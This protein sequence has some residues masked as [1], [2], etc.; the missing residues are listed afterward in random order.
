MRGR[1]AQ[2]TECDILILHNKDQKTAVVVVA[3]KKTHHAAESSTTAAV[4][5]YSS[6]CCASYLLRFVN[7]S[8][9]FW[10]TARVGEEK[11]TKTTAAEGRKH[12]G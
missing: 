5:V 4:L 11:K 7:Y 6:I 8:H 2:N 9:F 12:M 3:L 1:T 10:Q